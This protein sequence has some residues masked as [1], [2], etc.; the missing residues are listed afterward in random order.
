MAEALAPTWV[1]DDRENSLFRVHR[2]ALTSPAVY[3][4][5]YR[6]IFEKCWLYLGHES[7]IPRPGDFLT[8]VL[9]GRPL[10]L[11]RDQEGNLQVLIN[12]C[13][14]RGA[15]VC[16]DARGNTKTFRCFYHA[17]TYDTS[18]ALV[19]VPDAEGYPR[20]FR[21][22]ELGLR[23]PARVDS[24]RGF[25][26]VS[27]NPVV[28]GLPDYLSEATHY[29]D[30]I[31]DQSPDGMVVVEGTHDYSI[32][33]NWKLL[34]ENS[35]DGYHLVPLHKTYFAYQKTVGDGRIGKRPTRA[36]DLGNGHAVIRDRG[37]WGRPVARW[38][39]SFGDAAKERI[40]RR[41]EQLVEAFGAERAEQIAEDDCNLLIFPNLVIN[42]IMGVVV[43]TIWPT[44]PDHMQV[45][46]WALTP[47]G[48]PELRGIATNSFVSFLGPGG[49]AT[50]DDMEAL[51]SCQR[52]F[53]SV[54]EVEWSDMS[55][56][57]DTVE[58]HTSAQELQMQA[59]W[60]RW[61]T[62]MHAGD[63]ATEVI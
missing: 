54:R 37:P 17:W 36:L 41:Y 13:M 45:R 15:E 19:A 5:E 58:G 7:E 18:G 24:Y 55:R 35:L 50:P 30:L 33:A 2:S 49:F 1:R 22:D 53:G 47:A 42:D 11:C 59:F 31:A 8:R 9:A 3:E 16:R 39:P 10:I 60:R 48:D 40:E 29:L 62:L 26:F 23:R 56:G 63:A 43:R 51:E 57:M 6:R 4:L 21:Q 38:V 28:A 12:S 14:H 34:I 46:A 25:V 27:F 32:D 44:A 52:G 61:D 20:S